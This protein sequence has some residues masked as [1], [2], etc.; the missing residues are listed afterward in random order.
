MPRDHMCLVVAYYWHGFE[1]EWLKKVSQIGSVTRDM[2]TDML[3]SLDNLLDIHGFFH[4]EEV[5]QAMA[6]TSHNR[7]PR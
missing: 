3:S 2:I 1:V 5:Q 6:T 4:S 7:E